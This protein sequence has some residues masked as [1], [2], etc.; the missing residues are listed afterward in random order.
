MGNIKN[1]TGIH[2]QYIMR[3]WDDF[4]EREVIRHYSLDYRNINKDSN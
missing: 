1:E 4:I 2:D 3:G